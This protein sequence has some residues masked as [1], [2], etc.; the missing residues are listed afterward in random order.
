[1]KDFTS[2]FSININVLDTCIHASMHA[3]QFVSN[4]PSHDKFNILSSQGIASLFIKNRILLN[5]DACAYVF[6]SCK[7]TYHSPIRKRRDDGMG[8]SL[9]RLF[10]LADVGF[11]VSLQLLLASIGLQVLVRAA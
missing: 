4:S 10:T 5:N 7:R 8:T 1:M 11:G 9:M 3:T 6:K 2:I